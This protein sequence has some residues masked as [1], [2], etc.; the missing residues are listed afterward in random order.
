[1]INLSRFSLKMLI[2][3]DFF[4]DLWYN[5]R[6]K[7]REHLSVIGQIFHKDVL[8]LLKNP[9]ALIV[10]I[11]V[12]FLP[13]VYAWTTIGADW[14]PYGRTEALKVGIANQDK[15]AENALV[16]KI[17]IGDEVVQ[18][19]H[20]D[21]HLGW[22]FVDEQQAMDGVWSGEY[23][24][25]IVIPPEF[26][27][28][29]LSVFQGDFERP[30]IDYYVNEK[31]SAVAPELTNSG[32][33][34]VEQEIDAQFT[35]TVSQTVT[36][37]AQQAGRNL[38]AD[39]QEAS[40]ELGALMSTMRTDIEENSRVIDGFEG[41]IGTAAGAVNDAKGVVAELKVVLPG[42]SGDLQNAA[43]QLKEASRENQE[44]A[45]QVI[46]KLDQAVGELDTVAGQLESETANASEEIKALVQQLAMQ[47]REIAG[48]LRSVAGQFSSQ[49]LPDTTGALNQFA[50]AFGGLGG[51][52]T[53][54]TPV[55]TSTDA[56][57]AQLD[58]T[59]ILATAAGDS[60]KA[61]LDVILQSLESA[62]TDIAALHSSST[63]QKMAEFL[64]V[65]PEEIGEFMAAPVMLKTEALYPIK[66][67][68]TGVAPFFTNI[69]LW[70]AGFILVAI[71][72]IKIDPKGL[73]KFSMVEGYLGRLMLFVVLG[74]LQGVIVC[75]GD[76]IMGI[77]CAHPVAF[78][79]AGVV[80]VVVYVN[81]MY[82]LV[83]T[84][85][86]IGR[87]I[88]VVMLIM[89]IPGASGE[90]PVQMMPEFFQFI[91]PFLPFTYSIDAMREATGGM[92]G[93][94]YWLDLLAL[95][96]FLV[97]ALAVGIGLGRHAFNLN[98]LFDRELA[99]TD[100]F[101]AEPAGQEQKGFR[102]RYLVQVLLTSDTYR[103]RIELS[104]YRFRKHYPALKRIGWVAV[105]L[106]PVVTVVVNV[107]LPHDAETK[108]IL[109][110]MMVLG[111]I[112]AV[113]YLIV[114]EYINAS[115]MSRLGFSQNRRE[116]S[117]V[118]SRKRRRE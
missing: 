61:S 52:V 38:M 91:H 51:V 31:I 118:T 99:A 37:L 5:G 43:G 104:A 97:L 30:E 17:N 117:K 71:L 23:Y 83:W 18:K 59:L 100:L 115:M 111:I 46:R 55:L 95:V 9:L 110:L 80:S 72:H 39:G 45:E 98:A 114:V 19:L 76:L 65:S 94:Q 15:G 10:T 69:A 47:L 67:Y 33:D 12:L 70:V 16:G 113:I 68:G 105:V 2:F 22:Q 116:V 74:M 88:G 24:A 79:L 56:A 108:L 49:I 11:G 103:E 96:P 29:F 54:L 106:I 109:L 87:A 101:I 27:A 4:D 81:I 84:M 63:V 53:G 85:R 25:A 107:F 86:H 82:A 14:D 73:P 78:V 21:H 92:Y 41:T 93:N 75:V 42:I 58:T 36:E 44:A 32:A 8:S 90:Y 48:T 77:Q 6:M 40:G 34:T 57:L 60:V 102:L 66:N 62:S 1:M 13:S 3:I 112:M 20:Q 64:Q 89:Q 26:S 28:D 50:N 35:A 7:L